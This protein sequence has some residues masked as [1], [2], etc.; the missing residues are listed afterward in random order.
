[1]GQFNVGE[2][3]TC[4]P[5]ISRTA[6]PGDYKVVGEMPERD[7]DRMYR[8]KSPLE[9]HERVVGESLLVRSEGHLPDEAIAKRSRRGS[10]TLPKLRIALRID[11]DDESDGWSVLSVPELCEVPKHPD[12]AEAIGAVSA[13]IPETHTSELRAELEL[14][15]G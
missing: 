4:I 3:V 7:G 5:M 10:I 14:T 1:M 8:I 11:S 12:S 6:A 9:E 15:L 2:V 13:I